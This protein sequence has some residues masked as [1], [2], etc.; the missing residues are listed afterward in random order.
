MNEFKCKKKTK[1]KQMW[2]ITTPSLQMHFFFPHTLCCAGKKENINKIKY[3]LKLS[4]F[5]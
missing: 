1:K 5:G 4:N 3:E 2:V